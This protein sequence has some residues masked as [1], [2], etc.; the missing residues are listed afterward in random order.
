VKSK[1][2]KTGINHTEFS[3]KGYR[4]KGVLFSMMMMM[5]AMMN[6]FCTIA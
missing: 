1:E 5:M 4:S 3:K 2:V 6:Y